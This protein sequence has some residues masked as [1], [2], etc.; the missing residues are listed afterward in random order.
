M[1]IEQLEFFNF[2]HQ[3]WIETNVYIDISEDYWHSH[4]LLEL[5]LPLG[6]VAASL[7][8]PIPMGLHSSFVRRPFRSSSQE[9]LCKSLPN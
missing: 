6:H 1:A 7:R 9:K 2:P 4:L 5:S 8:W 3:L